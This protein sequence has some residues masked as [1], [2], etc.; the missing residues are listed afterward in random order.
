[1]TLSHFT[2]R[3]SGNRQVSIKGCDNLA[4]NFDAVE[5]EY[6]AFRLVGDHENLP[7]FYGAYLNKYDKDDKDEVWLIMEV[8]S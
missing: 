1:M 3:L 6:R 2:L 8:R 4:K 7:K 5:E